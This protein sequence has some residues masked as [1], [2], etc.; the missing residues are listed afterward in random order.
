MYM[1]IRTV[2]YKA[3]RLEI[4]SQHDSKLD[5]WTGKEKVLVPSIL[6]VL[7][8]WLVN[9]LLIMVSMCFLQ[10]GE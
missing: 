6:P 9:L 5:Q 8:V 7:K 1:Y 2:K 10:C 4:T 3:D